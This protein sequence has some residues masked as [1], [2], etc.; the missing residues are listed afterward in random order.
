MEDNNQIYNNI[1]KRRSCRKFLDKDI[2]AENIDRILK[3]GLSAPSAMNLQPWHF[4]VIRN[5][6]VIEELN[7][8]AKSSFQNSNVK[9]R[10]NWANMPNFSPFYSPNV[11]ILIC[12]NKNIKK[13]MNDCCFAVENMSLM[14]SSLGIGSCIIQD[15]CW[16]ITEENKAHFNIPSDYSIYLSL[17]LGYPTNKIDVDRTF[18]MKKISII[19]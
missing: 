7:K 8:L 3:C 12:Y 4:V 18:D 17:S 11:L 5:K 9:W 13:A 1:I 2:S 6:A 14:A 16:A 19:D 10:E 15:I